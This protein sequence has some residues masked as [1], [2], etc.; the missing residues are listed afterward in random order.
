M[1]STLRPAPVSTYRF[2]YN[3]D[4]RTFVAFLSDLPFSEFGRVYAD[5]VD[6][7]LTLIS[8]KTNKEIVFVVEEIK[9]REGD[10]LAWELKAVGASYSMKIFND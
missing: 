1:A 5:S 7:G 4:T 3:E 2:T 8:A 9:T 6:E 10:I